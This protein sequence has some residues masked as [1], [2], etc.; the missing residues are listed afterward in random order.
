MLLSILYNEKVF[1]LNKYTI[2]YEK[3]NIGFVFSLVFKKKFYIQKFIG[4]Y[5]EKVQ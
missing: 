3:I 5:N 4:G 2:K 1:K